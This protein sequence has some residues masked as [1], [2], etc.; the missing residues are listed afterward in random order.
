MMYHCEE[1]GA[2][3]N[4]LYNY[5]GIKAHITAHGLEHDTTM[6]RYRAFFPLPLDAAVPP[7][8]VGGTPLYDCPRLAK[9][10]GIAKLHIKDEGRNPTA[11]LKDRAS[12]LVVALVE[13]QKAGIITTAST[14][15]AGAAL[16][17][18][19]A[20]TGSPVVIF[21]PKTAPSAKIAQLQAFGAK[22][23]L[24][25]GTYDDAFA[26]CVKAT[27]KHG[28]YNRNTGSNPFTA[29][30]K[31]SVSL[32][33]G[34]QL[35]EGYGSFRAPDAVFVSVGDGNIITGVYK[36]FRDLK[37]CG[38]IP[39]MPKIFGV[40]SEHSDFLY[41]CQEA[42]LSPQ[43]V[44]TAPPR[45]GGAPT[46]ADSISAALPSD[47][48]NAYK[49]VMATGGRFVRVT[50]QDILAQ[51]PVIAAATGVFSEPA[52]SASVAGL[53]AA[54]A[55]GLISP[56]SEVVCISTGSGLKDVS[57]VAETLSSPPIIPK[58]DAGMVQLGEE[59]KK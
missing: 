26:L 27:E 19:A 35:A 44:H 29:A 23:L 7:L 3:L 34:E 24:V 18:V 45:E 15:N 55:A 33:I 20:S 54:L 6:W 39:E 56:D 30:G 40:Q 4:P 17:G 59:L 22:V 2:N 16:A 8:T 10:L 9:Q 47:R 46:R 53:R 52:A 13:H 42:G 32:E 5:D 49:G 58:G 21:V 28:W 31:K 1:E 51:I 48:T 12:A 37:A 57:A 38:L 14:G 43:Q 36:G 41:S 11:S 50:D 25:D